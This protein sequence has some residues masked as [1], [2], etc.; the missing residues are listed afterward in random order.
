MEK[1]SNYKVSIVLAAYNTVAY[2]SKCLD[3]I[4]IRDDVEVV[5]IDD[6]STDGTEIA[7]KKY[8]EVNPNAKLIRN[9]HNIGFAMSINRAYD[10][11]SGEYITQLDSD[12]Y[13]FTDVVN[14]IISHD[15]TADL[16][17]FD[18]KANDGKIWHCTPE[19]R[20]IF[21][22]HVFFIKRD[23]LGAHRRPNRPWGS[24]ID[25]NKAIQSEVDAFN[26][27]IKYTKKVAYMYNFPRE[28]SILDKRNKGLL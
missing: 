16:V 20:D 14:D 2:I 13:Y 3:S 26:K 18:L 21:M 19:T 4:P 12:D 15:L 10:E 17:Y 5:I 23:L 24:G 22:D 28:G 9:E 8:C 11:C 1:E 27:T 6:C 25:F 7:L